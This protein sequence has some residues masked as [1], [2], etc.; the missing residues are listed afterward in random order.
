METAKYSNQWAQFQRTGRGQW[1]PQVGSAGLLKGECVV[2]LLH[3]RSH[4]ASSGNL[5]WSSTESVYGHGGVCV[6]EY[7]GGCVCLLRVCKC[8]CV[9][10]CVSYGSAH[11]KSVCSLCFSLFAVHTPE[12]SPRCRVLSAGRRSPGNPAVTDTRAPPSGETAKLELNS[13]HW[14]VSDALAAWPSGSRST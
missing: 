9:W 3:K 4:V 2:L 5:T 10:E 13:I 1:C 6:T 14:L 11:L 12:P 7:S 8:V